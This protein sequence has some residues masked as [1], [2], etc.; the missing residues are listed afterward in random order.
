LYSPS[1]DTSLLSSPLEVLTFQFCDFPA[2]ASSASSR[3]ISAAAK[4]YS[5][6]NNVVEDKFKHTKLIRKLDKHDF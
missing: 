1:V 6:S 4:A 2:S 3:P 5:Y